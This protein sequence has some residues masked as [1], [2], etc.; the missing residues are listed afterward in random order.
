[1]LKYKRALID[2]KLLECDLKC[3]RNY[4]YGDGDYLFD[5]IAYLLYYEISS[6]KVVLA[7]FLDTCST[8]FYEGFRFCCLFFVFMVTKWASK[9]FS[10]SLL[11]ATSWPLIPKGQMMFF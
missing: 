2:R 4:K 9:G 1:M 8:R 6:K 7:F 3:N 10:W 5:F 11:V